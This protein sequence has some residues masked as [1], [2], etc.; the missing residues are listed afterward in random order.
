[1]TSRRLVVGADGWVAAAARID[2]PN[3]DARPDA[4]PPTLVVIHGISLPPGEFGGD[5]IVR[6]FTNT[7]DPAAHPYY[8]TIAAF[9]VSAHFLIRR[10][11]TLVQFVSCAERA[12]HAGVSS[13]RGRARCNDYSIGIE[14]EGTDDRPY[15]A[16]QYAT[17]AALLTALRRRYPLEAAVGHSDVAPDRKTDPGPAFDWNLLARRTGARRLHVA[18]GTPHGTEA[19]PAGPAPAARARRIRSAV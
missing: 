2:S 13:W 4:S 9:R 15:T 6:L 18:A 1:M 11:G 12:W 8:A 17:L 7:L 16:R 5:A 3:R 10:D 19:P 14:L